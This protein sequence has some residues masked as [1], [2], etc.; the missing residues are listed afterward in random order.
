QSRLDSRSYRSG[1]RG[2]EAVAVPVDRAD[3]LL[4]LEPERVDHGGEVG[5]DIGGDWL[6]APELN[7][8]RMT[9]LITGQ[10][11][12]AR[13]ARTRARPASSGPYTGWPP[14]KEQR[15]VPQ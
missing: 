7:R 11:P 12:R 10:A 3:D 5:G 2:D 6:R 1:E 8:K 4:A 15:Q 14:L 13:A 9:A